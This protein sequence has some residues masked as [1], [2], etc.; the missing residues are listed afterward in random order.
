MKHLSL[1]SQALKKPEPIKITKKQL[2][3]GKDE[4]LSIPGIGESILEHL[5]HA[6]IINKIT[7]QK[8]DISG[9][10][11]NSGLSKEHIKKLKAAAG[12]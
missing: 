1:I 11:T 6:G 10:S 5:Y 8:A 4:L 3:S 7:L 2:E 9:I 12:V